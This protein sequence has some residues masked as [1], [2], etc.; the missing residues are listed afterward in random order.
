MVCVLMFFFLQFRLSLTRYKVEVFFNNINKNQN[1]YNENHKI[2]FIQI[3]E[4][5]NSL[6]LQIDRDYMKLW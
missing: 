4:F 3:Y 2:S 5:K 1:D 6:E